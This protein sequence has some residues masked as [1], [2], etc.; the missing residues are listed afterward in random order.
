MGTWVVK[1]VTRAMFYAEAS[2]F[3]LGSKHNDM[4]EEQVFDTPRPSRL[5]VQTES[6]GLTTRDR[7]RAFPKAIL[8]TW[9]VA[10]MPDLRRI[11]GLG[12]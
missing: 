3:F 12:H 9:M 8:H 5:T 10:S 4:I 7:R 11:F 1:R 6:L 2:Y